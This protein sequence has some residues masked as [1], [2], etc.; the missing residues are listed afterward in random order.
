MYEE[1]NA[2]EEEIPDHPRKCT[3]LPRVEPREVFESGSKPL[4][5]DAKPWCPDYRVVDQQ[6]SGVCGA[7]GQQRT[8]VEILEAINKMQLQVDQQIKTQKLPRLRLCLSMEIL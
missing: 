8:G 2:V 3:P 7:R 4:N 1:F 6:S 5:P